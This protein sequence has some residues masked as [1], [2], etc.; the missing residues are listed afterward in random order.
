MGCPTPGGVSAPT[1]MIIITAMMNFSFYTHPLP[2][3]M[4]NAN[5]PT[6]SQF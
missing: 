1:V 4:E 3:I 2:H 5:E 6:E